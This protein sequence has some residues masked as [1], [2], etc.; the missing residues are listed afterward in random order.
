MAHFGQIMF[1]PGRPTSKISAED[2]F[3]KI[4]DA[5]TGHISKSP[6]K[7][8]PIMKMLLE[9]KQHARQGYWENAIGALLMAVSAYNLEREPQVDTSY[10]KGGR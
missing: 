5:M 9:A 2:A 8:H 6:Y 4:V 1:E 3:Y 7:D 10:K